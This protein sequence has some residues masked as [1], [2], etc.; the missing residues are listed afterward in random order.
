MKYSYN[1]LLPVQLQSIL[2]SAAE[3]QRIEAVDQ[4]IARVH[5]LAPERFHNEK[6]L[7]G[8]KFHHEPRQFI[9]NAGFNVPLPNTIV[10][11]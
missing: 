3:T 10:R 8:R 1:S 2:M 11:D 6:T 5:G 4:A 9:P 7:S